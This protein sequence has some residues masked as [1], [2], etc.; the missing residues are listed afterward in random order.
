LISEKSEF[1]VLGGGVAGMVMCLLIKARRP[2][3]TI[4]LV[5]G[6]SLLGG[7]L[8]GHSVLG[9]FFDKGT[10]IPQ[11]S[12]D[13]EID[14]LLRRAVREESLV[15]MSAEVG[16]AVATLNDAGLSLATAYPDVLSLGASLAEEIHQQILDLVREPTV[17]NFRHV[18][19]LPLDEVVGQWFGPLAQQAVTG[20]Q[21]ERHFG[22]RTDM[23]AFALEI[24]NLSRLNLVSP[25]TWMENRHS[26]A[27]R[28]RV[29]FPDQ[30]ALP[31]EYRHGRKSLYSTSRGST[32][33]ADGLAQ[34]CSAA[35]V[36][37]LT[38]TRIEEIDVENG[39]V[40][41]SRHGSS[42]IVQC[43]RVVSSLGPSITRSLVE[44]RPY[45]P[46]DRVSYRL[47][48][49]ILD[50]KIP[51]DFAYLYNHCSSG[52]FFRLTN[53]G[54]FSGRVSDTRIT[55]EVLGQERIPDSS[56]VTVVTDELMKVGLVGRDSVRSSVVQRENSGFPIPTVGTFE[57]FFEDYSVLSETH[58]DH[59]I[60]VGI[61][62]GGGDFFQNEILVRG[63]KDIREMMSVG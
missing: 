11:E 39:R 53:Y 20:P 8:R 26:V 56:L 37:L 51:G 25:V 28:R 58:G 63:A 41:M 60:T 35:G 43:N 34:L 50:Q 21:V 36:R 12:G 2:T 59:L 7:N 3:A 48:H 31:D 61:G 49:M 45:G 18:R 6:S 19:G 62:A 40:L 32:D 27:Y 17:E 22:C 46:P 47:V 14:A 23:A 1:V 57:Q 33:F 42:L 38:E 52:S 55:V 13:A 16:D 10:H 54:H 29:A 30:L 4:C 5:E 24:L 15:E 44:K 9:D